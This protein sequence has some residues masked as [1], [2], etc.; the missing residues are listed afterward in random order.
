MG[1]K[2]SIPQ[3][4]DECPICYTKQENKSDGIILNCGHYFNNF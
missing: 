4:N 1:N 2:K 3:I